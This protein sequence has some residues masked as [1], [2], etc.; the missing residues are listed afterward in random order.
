VRQYLYPLEKAVKRHSQCAEKVATVTTSVAMLQTTYTWVVAAVAAVA[1][2][3]SM[4]N[5]KIR[6]HTLN[7]VALDGNR[8]ELLMVKV[9]VV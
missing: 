9:G 3:T 1:T 4:P 2:P 6:T 8:G 5:E 7:N